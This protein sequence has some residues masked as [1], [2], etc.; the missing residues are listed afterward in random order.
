MRVSSAQFNI[1]Q[2][3][4]TTYYFKLHASGINHKLCTITQLQVL[5]NI[6]TRLAHLVLHYRHWYQPYF[7][8]I[9]SRNPYY[10]VGSPAGILVS[11]IPSRTV[12]L[13]TPAFA[14]IFRPRRT[15]LCWVILFR[16]SWRIKNQL[17]R[18]IDV[19]KTFNTKN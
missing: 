10:T 13:R 17:M 9:C 11:G 1:S 6:Q 14:P 18:Y 16:C 15:R 12:H 8:I 19:R 2:T 7:L 4:S 3:I 5:K